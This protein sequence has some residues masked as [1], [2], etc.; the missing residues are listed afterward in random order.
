MSLQEGIPD[1]EQSWSI[2][3]S[4]LKNMKEIGHG[5]F[6]K[7][8][9]AEFLGAEVAV[10]KIE[11][12]KIKDPAEL[13]FLK[14]EIAILKSARHPNIV[15]FLGVA[16][17]NKDKPNEEALLVMELLSKGPL[18]NYLMEIK[19]EIC[20]KHRIQMA[21]DIACAMTYLHSRKIIFRDMKTKNL[22]LD[23][24]GK[25]KIIDFGLARVHDKSSRPKTLCGTDEY[26]APEVIL[27]LDYGEKSDVFSYGLVLFEI[28]T[29]TKFG[30]E[31]PRTPND[32]FGINEE[33]I[34]E[35][36]LMPPDCPPYF[37]ELAFFC[38][39][40]E[41]KK[42]PNF[43]QVLEFMKKLK[44]VINNET[45]SKSLPTSPQTRALPP[46]PTPKQQNGST[47]KEPEKQNPPPIAPRKLAA[48][49][50]SSSISS[51]TPS[52]SN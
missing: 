2:D 22:L 34:K 9:K 21:L 16:T 28:I 13:L 38:C 47:K 18:R 46:N 40:Y 27:G 48:S 15:T 30:K 10:K 50:S 25:V 26:M 39:K 12:S 5:A 7:V 42:R 41:E 14:R 3:P 45:L 33:K 35:S 23:D 31:I 32:A 20:W 29:R 1:L 8:Y 44:L 4:D 36:G 19:E 24:N 6:G 51:T 49:S 37:Q 11:I 17:V 52:T 43:K